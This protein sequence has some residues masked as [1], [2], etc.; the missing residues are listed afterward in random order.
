MAIEAAKP[1]A[2]NIYKVLIYFEKLYAV[3]DE[4][5]RRQLMES[6]LSEVHIYEDRQQN[7]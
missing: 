1:T 6:L 3:M 2:D 4:A 5:E 7:G